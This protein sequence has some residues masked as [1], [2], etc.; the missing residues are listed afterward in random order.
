MTTPPRGSNPALLT[1]SEAESRTTGN[2]KTEIKNESSKEI[3]TTKKNKLSSENQMASS[4]RKNL[5][6]RESSPLETKRVLKSI[7]QG[8]K[9]SLLSRK[10]ATEPVIAKE[11][12]PAPGVR[13]MENKD[14]FS[15]EIKLQLSQLPNDR[16]TLE[17]NEENL[18]DRAASNVKCTKLPPTLIASTQTSEKSILEASKIYNDHAHHNGQERR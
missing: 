15:K 1:K 9:A 2:E 6:S 8:H 13:S 7:A 5:F 18:I 10:S 11:F 17:R 14:D 4:P 16:S 3:E 12:A